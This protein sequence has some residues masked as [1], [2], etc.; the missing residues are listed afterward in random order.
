MCVF[1]NGI[2]VFICLL[3]KNAKIYLL[4]FSQAAKLQQLEGFFPINPLQKVANVQCSLFVSMKINEIFLMDFLLKKTY[5]QQ[6]RKSMLRLFDKKQTRSAII[7][8]VHDNLSRKKIQ[9]RF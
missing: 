1:L 8:T 5:L 7:S 3:K 9:N 6:K 4:H 2:P